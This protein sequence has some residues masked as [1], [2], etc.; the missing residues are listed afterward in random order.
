VVAAQSRRG[1]LRV[2]GTSV[3]AGAPVLLGAC[4]DDGGAAPT[5]TG[6][7]DV[8]LLNNLL[9]LEHQAADA[10]RRGLPLL[11][12][13]QRVL[14]ER[15]L[16]Q[17]HEQAHA[18]AEGIT[19]LGGTPHGPADHYELPVWHTGSD[20]LSFADTLETVTVA[21]YLDAIA[22][23]TDSRLRGTVAAIMTTTA[24]HILVLRE[25]LGSTEGPQNFVVGQR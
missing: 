5:K 22:K 12:G 13:G 4:G 1:F 25:A 2:A 16:A 15:F 3:L 23:I 19:R 21:G 20:V 14:G 11:T 17:E 24:E 10:Y 8:D 9:D 18:L 6:P 7:A